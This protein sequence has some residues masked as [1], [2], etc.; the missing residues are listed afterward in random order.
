MNRT[1]RQVLSAVPELNITL[2]TVEALG[3]KA[4]DIGNIKH[5]IKY[6]RYF[7]RSMQ[8]SLEDAEI[9]QHQEVENTD[10]MVE[11]LQQ[12]LERASN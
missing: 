12:L 8:D 6:N 4:L 2:E 10:K 11:E 5:F 7:I 1:I 9:V 3:D